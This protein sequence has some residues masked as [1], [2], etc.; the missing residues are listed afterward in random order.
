MGLFNRRRRADVDTVDDGRSRGYARNTI[1]ALFTFAGAAA[2]GLLIWLAHY[3]G[4]KS[5]G[6]FWGSMGL[7]AGAGLVLGLSQLFGGWTKWG[8]P[9]LSAAVLLFGWIP[10]AVVTGWILIA[11]QPTRGWQEGRLDSWSSSIG[12]GGFVNDFVPYLP[13]LA[14]GLGIVTAFVFD[15]T[16][17]RVRRVD[18]APDTVPDEDVHD[19][20]REEA[21]GRPGATTTGT[22][23]DTTTD[24]TTDEPVTT[25]GRD[26][27]VEIHD[28][29]R[30]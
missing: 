14:L 24:E 26:D 22:T 7:I 23:T 9:K 5:T 1:R 4:M 15:T 19:Y 12:V 11:D 16:G 8:W 25:A 2:A 18:A 17:P 3:L 28:P 10:A 30:R 27:R 13:A 6:D 20:R 29:A 21:V